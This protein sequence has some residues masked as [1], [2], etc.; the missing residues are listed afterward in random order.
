MLP[1]SRSVRR[2]PTSTIQTRR[3]TS[4]QTTRR[5]HSFEPVPIGGGDDR[6]SWSYS[7]PAVGTAE[8]SISPS[9]SRPSPPST[10]SC[11]LVDADLGRGGLSHYLN[12]QDRPG[13]TDA[14]IDQ[15]RVQVSVTTIDNGSTLAS[16]L[17]HQRHGKHWCTQR[18]RR[19]S[20]HAAR[21]IRCHHRPGTSIRRGRSPRRVARGGGWHPGRW[22]RWEDDGGRTGAHLVTSS[23][24]W[25][26]PTCIEE[27]CWAPIASPSRWV[28]WRPSALT[29]R[30][31]PPHGRIVRAPVPPLQPPPTAGQDRPASVNPSWAACPPPRQRST[32]P[33][34]VRGTPVPRGPPSGAEPRP[35]EHP[36][37]APEPEV[38]WAPFHRS[39]L[40][41]RGSC[42]FGARTAGRP[43][44]R[45]EA[46]A[47]TTSSHAE[48]QRDPERPRTDRLTLMGVDQS[49]R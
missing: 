21:R 32:H 45:D 34:Q 41:L 3:I 26:S 35:I 46:A 6:C 33:S 7:F 14:Q 49:F 19:P 29:D 16:P 4:V 12:R 23:A 24:R 13:V 39:R 43:P 5:T 38:A 10:G 17:P 48:R 28:R 40:R 47:P 2:Y 44:E 8:C 36:H 15:G 22:D 20:G 37:P 31:S 25:R 11:L 1:G 42:R 27:Y 9:I 18:H 30:P